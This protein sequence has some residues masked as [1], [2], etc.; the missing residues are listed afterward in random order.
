[1]DTKQ[2]I[3]H[4]LETLGLTRKWLGDT[5]GYS[6]Y[7]VRDCLAPD[8]KKLS[9]RMAAAFLAA[10]EAEEQARATPPPPPILPDRITLEVP[11][12]KM[13]RW[14]EAAKGT[15]YPHTKAW[16]IA[17]LNRAAE[18]WHREQRHHAPL[19][20][21]EAPAQDPADAAAGRRAST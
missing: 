9:N 10:I 1:M 3:T 17:E 19:R 5:T 15:D 2:T 20:P 21:A 4:R 7:S 6:Y 14:D 13:T 18:A 12:E 8:G 16:A 11:P